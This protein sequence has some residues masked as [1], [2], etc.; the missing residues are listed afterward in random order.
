MRERRPRRSSDTGIGDGTMADCA[1]SRRER[2]CQPAA[3]I[4]PR[5]PEQDAG[6]T[7]PSPWMFAAPP[8]PQAVPASRMAL[9]GRFAS[10][11]VDDVGTDA[12]YR[13]G[14]QG[15]DTEHLQAGSRQTAKDHGRIP[16][17]GLLARSKRGTRFRT[18]SL[19]GG[20]KQ[21]RRRFCS[22]SVERDQGTRRCR[23]RS[24][25]DRNWR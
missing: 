6:V 7:A 19:L 8:L 22:P 17:V 25:D 1:S 3:R 15:T 2:R 11:A 21:R 13:Q 9:G 23:W 10:T 20:T 24:L 5:S 4:R 14:G 18:A 12:R 16:G